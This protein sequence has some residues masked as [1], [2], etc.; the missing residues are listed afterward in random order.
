MA[1]GRITRHR[2]SVHLAPTPHVVTLDGR[3]DFWRAHAVEAEVSRA[4]RLGA[5]RFVVDLT[6]VLSLDSVMLRSLIVAQKDVRGLR[7]RLVFACGDRAARRL[8]LA[9]GLDG[10]MDVVGT[11]EEALARLQA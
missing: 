3:A 7:G 5:R 1:R 11:R 8:F 9:T 2:R 10:V 4:L 6:A